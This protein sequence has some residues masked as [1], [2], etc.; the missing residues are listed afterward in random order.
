MVSSV[1]N[2]QV[3]V[4]KSRVAFD[5]EECG[6]PGFGE[7]LSGLKASKSWYAKKRIKDGREKIR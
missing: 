4:H 5:V 7:D 2:C 3:E 6:H 1:N